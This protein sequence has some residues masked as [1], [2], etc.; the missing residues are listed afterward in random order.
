MRV[1]LVLELRVES[2]RRADGDA[3]Y[4][5][6]LRRQVRS[7]KWNKYEVDNP[8]GEVTVLDDA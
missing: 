2:L 4:V 3:R 8:C 6:S 1:V 7:L 5:E